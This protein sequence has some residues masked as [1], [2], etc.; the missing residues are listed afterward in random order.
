MANELVDLYLKT[1]QIVTIKYETNYTEARKPCKLRAQN[2][3]T[4]INY[5]VIYF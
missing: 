2:T 4:A 5:I 3:T 1:A